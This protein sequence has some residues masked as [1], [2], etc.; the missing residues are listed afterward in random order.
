MLNRQ[1]KPAYNVQIAVEN[2]FIVHCYVVMIMQ[3]IYIIPVLEKHKKN[4]R[5]RYP[6][7][8]QT[9]VVVEKNTLKIR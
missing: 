1:L 9:A 2:Y 6:R 8:W 7:S 4:F 5:E 3:I